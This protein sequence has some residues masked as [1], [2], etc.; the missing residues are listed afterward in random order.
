MEPSKIHLVHWSNGLSKSHTSRSLALVEATK[1]L[2]PNNEHKYI[3]TPRGV[4]ARRFMLNK[5]E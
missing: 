4:Y 5:G 1:R 2:F 3:Q